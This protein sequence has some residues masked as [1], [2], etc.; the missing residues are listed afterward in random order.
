MKHAVW[1]IVFIV[2]CTL[3]AAPLS[4]QGPDIDN[5]LATIRAATFVIQQTREARENEAAQQRLTATAIAIERIRGEATQRAADY[6]TRQSLDVHATRQAIDAQAARERQ[7]AGATATMNA[8]RIE[9]T[10]IANYATATA[11]IISADQTRAAA[12]ATLAAE[13]TATRRAEIAE[14]DRRQGE[15]VN[16]VVT[17]A[18]TVSASIIIAIILAIVAMHA[19]RQTSPRPAP[20]Q[21]VVEIIE[22]ARDIPPQED[23]EIPQ[24]FQSPKTEIVFDPDIVAEF[25]RL[26]KLNA[27]YTLPAA[28]E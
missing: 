23:L 9:Q 28:I 22:P 8:L 17:G 16:G 25:E 14:E 3:F 1:L 11:V 6:A 2:V 12:T 4:A 7:A 24:P 18:V 10:R 20:A 27:V 19:F 5:A 13:R 15:R 21:A 26:M